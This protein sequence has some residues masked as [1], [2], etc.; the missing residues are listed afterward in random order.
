MPKRKLERFAELGLL[1]RV[2]QPKGLFL[3]HDHELKGRWNKEV[4]RNNY[5][6]IIELG[7]GRGEYTV[8]MARRYP[9]CNFVGIDIKGAR[10]WR[11]A[12][13]ANEEQLINAAFLRYQIEQLTAFFAPGEVSEIWITFPDP[14]PQKTRENR[15]MTSHRFLKMYR[16]LVGTTGKVH[17]KTDNRIL[18]EYTL[19]KLNEDKVR[20]HHATDNLYAVQ[21]NETVLEIKTT[22]EKKFLDLGMDICYISFSFEE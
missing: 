12:K 21:L 9:N 19:E 6:I 14:Q 11:G 4:F 22:Y 20:I 5:P 3:D 18:Y 7:C 1:D 2:Y 13:T 15:R 10:L 17:L 16:E 8:N